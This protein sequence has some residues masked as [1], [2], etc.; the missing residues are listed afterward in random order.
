M[1]NDIANNNDIKRA[2]M[3]LQDA[4][5]QFSEEVKKDQVVQRKQYEITV[6]YSN[7]H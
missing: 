3:I 2:E 7:E 4:S 5:K 1:E 6:N